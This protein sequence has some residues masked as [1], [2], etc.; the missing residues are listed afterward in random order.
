MNITQQEALE[1]LVIY[2]KRRAAEYE[3]GLVVSNALVEKL[4]KTIENFTADAGET[5]SE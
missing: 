5:D 1:S 3:E 2:Y 4:R